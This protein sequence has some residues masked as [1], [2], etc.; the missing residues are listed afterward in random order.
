ML[1]QFWLRSLAPL[2]SLSSLG[3][4]QPETE[5]GQLLLNTVTLQA[6]AQ[7][8]L[9]ANAGVPLESE[10]LPRAGLLS[11]ALLGPTPRSL[12]VGLIGLILSLLLTRLN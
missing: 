12:K 3:S 4:S 11:L 6:R 10:P 8:G 9:P 2:S 1:N 7:G 5:C